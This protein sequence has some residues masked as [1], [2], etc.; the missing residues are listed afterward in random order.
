MHFHLDYKPTVSQQHISH[1]QGI[2]LMGSCFSEHIADKLTIRKFTVDTNPFGIVFNPKSIEIAIH[3]MVNKIYY[4]EKDVFEKE[5]FWFCLETH[6][7]I[8]AN[9]SQELITLLNTIIN[10]WHIKLKNASWLILTLGSAYAYKHSE[11]QQI[12]ANCHKLPST[13]FEKKLLQPNDLVTDYSNL[14]KTIKQLNP[15]IQLIFTVSPVKHLRDGLI[16]NSLSKAILLQTIHQLV[17]Q[18]KHCYYFPAYELVID[19]LRDYRF[20]EPDMAHPNQ[21]AIDYVW[22]KFE[23]VYF[24]IVTK[25]IN[26]KLMDIHLALNH[27]PFNSNSEASVKFKTT[28]Y[29]KC[30]ALKKQYPWI[31][32][33]LEKKYFS[34]V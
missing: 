7:S 14:I 26:E 10:E 29:K 18:H 4:K 23:E 5:G 27:K 28:Y 8:F 6:T 15:T 34:T 21:Q 1:Q 13:L 12:V 20:Y 16:E 25:S 22:Q 3:R 2:L 31:N 30:E 9:T 11:Q 19:D 24:S 17:N 32:L 33:E